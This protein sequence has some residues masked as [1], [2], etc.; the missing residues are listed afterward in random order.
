MCTYHK[1][2]HSVKF[3]KGEGFQDNKQVC[4]AVHPVNFCI[5][6]KFGKL[7]VVF[8][9][10]EWTITHLFFDFRFNLKTG[11]RETLEGTVCFWLTGPTSGLQWA[12]RSLFGAT[13][14]RRVVYVMRWG[15]AFW[16]ETFAGGVGLMPWVSGMICQFSGMHWYQCWSLG[17]GVRQIGATKAPSQPTPNAQVFWRQTQT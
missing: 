13:S 17:S 14:S 12:T 3:A 7:M 15:C 8:D 10:I 16:L 1:W 2:H 11:R 6:Q 9:F 4:V 5:D